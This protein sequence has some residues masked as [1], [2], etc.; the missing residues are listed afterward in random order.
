VLTL[1]TEE[2]MVMFYEDLPF[3]PVVLYRRMRAHDPDAPPQHS[4]FRVGDNGLPPTSEDCCDRLVSA[5][6][7]LFPAESERLKHT[8]HTLRIGGQ[9]TYKAV[10]LQA[11][12]DAAR[13]GAPVS[14][15]AMGMANGS[16][17]LGRYEKETI[18]GQ[19]AAQ[20][21]MARA[22]V[23]QISDVVAGETR[24]S[25]PRSKRSKVQAA[26]DANQ[27]SM[28]DFW[29]ASK[30]P[31]PVIEEGGAARSGLCSGRTLPPVCSADG[32]PEWAKLQHDVCCWDGFGWD[33]FLV[34]S[35]VTICRRYQFRDEHPFEEC[36]WRQG[37][38]CC[39]CGP[40][41]GWGHGACAC[42][43]HPDGARAAREFRDM[44]QTAGPV[45]AA[46][47]W[48]CMVL[49]PEEEEGQDF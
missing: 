42:T 29:S 44:V 20:F 1:N 38:F 8:K 45:E 4:A 24:S 40:K 13:G 21:L 37:H 19:V 30:A 11:A 9:T 48:T 22:E 35:G 43:V 18:Q 46:G 15:K 10:E 41:G 32:V 39:L 36:A 14:Q 7:L 23:D 49:S 6:Q 16:R 17:I 31:E 2:Q 28:R 5:G 25:V 47:I 27:S 33:R 12:M 34:P 26:S 3:N